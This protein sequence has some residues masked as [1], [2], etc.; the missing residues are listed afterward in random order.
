VGAEVGEHRPAVDEQ[1]DDDRQGQR[2]QPEPAEDQRRGLDLA[3]RH[4]DE[5]ER[6]APDQRERSEEHDRAAA[7]HLCVLTIRVRLV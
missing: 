4:L 1:R 6:A 5:H 2:R 7:G 3:I